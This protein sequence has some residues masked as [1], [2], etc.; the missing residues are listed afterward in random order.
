MNRGT[1]RDTQ[2][3]RGRYYQSG[4]DARVGDPHGT[5]TYDVILHPL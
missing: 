1:F 5:G 2:G 3:R 4:A